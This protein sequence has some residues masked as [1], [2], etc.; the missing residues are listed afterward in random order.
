MVF[1]KVEETA[2]IGQQIGRER[3]KIRPWFSIA[4]EV[5]DDCSFLNNKEDPAVGMVSFENY[6]N[7]WH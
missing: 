2:L 1:L 3:I 5:F 7:Y 4:V 6:Y